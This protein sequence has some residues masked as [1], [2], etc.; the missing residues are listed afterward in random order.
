MAKKQKAEKVIVKG[1][2]LISFVIAVALFVLFNYASNL[3][4]AQGN[5]IFG[6]SFELLQ[7]IA[8]KPEIVEGMFNADNMGPHVVFGLMFIILELILA[9]ILAI[10]TI[11]LFFGLF[12]FIGKKDAKVVAK[13]LSKYAKSALAGVAIVIFGLLLFAADDGNLSKDF[14]D[15]TLYAGIAFGVL[16]VLVRFYRWFIASKRPILDSV[17]EVVKDVVYIGSLIILISFIEIGFLGEF[18]T[19]QT[20]TNTHVIDGGIIQD[21]MIASIMSMCVSV[22]QFF[23]ITSMMRK[24]LRLLPFN[25]YKRTAYG[26]LK[27]G[28]IAYFI[29]TLIMSVLALIMG[30]LIAGTFDAANILPLALDLL[31]MILPQLLAMVAV[32]VADSIEEEK[33]EF[34][35]PLAVQQKLAEKAALEA[36]EAVSEQA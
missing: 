29:I 20:I 28:F 24:T 5:S 7:E 25:N 22:F 8:E 30:D 6:F 9:I 35:Y 19:I 1:F 34:A 3:L 2:G 36:E 26:K 10:K 21:Q 15:L 4:I 27:G 12:G 16:Y 23:I 17:F 31:L 32:I 11:T 33:P 14:G 18:K 13:K